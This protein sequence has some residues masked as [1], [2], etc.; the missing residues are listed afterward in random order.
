M[1]IFFYIVYFNLIYVFYDVFLKLDCFV[2][3]LLVKYFYFD[4]GLIIRY[5]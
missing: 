5:G 3:D 1:D 4:I 2:K